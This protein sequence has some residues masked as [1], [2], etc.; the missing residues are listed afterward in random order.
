MFYTKKERKRAAKICQNVNNIFLTLGFV[1]HN[2][3]IVYYFMN[4][5]VN[6]FH[7]V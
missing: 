3:A 4:K 6:S 5:D 1:P 7:T 2:N